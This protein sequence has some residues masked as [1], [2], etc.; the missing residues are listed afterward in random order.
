MKKVKVWDAVRETLDFL[1]P[2]LEQGMLMLRG[3]VDGWA[4]IRKQK[5]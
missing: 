3:E 4:M 2:N 1:L 5:I